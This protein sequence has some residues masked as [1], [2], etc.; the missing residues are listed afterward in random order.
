MRLPACWLACA[1]LVAAQTDTKLLVDKV[2]LYDRTHVALTIELK[3]DPPKASLLQ[4]TITVS[5][6]DGPHGSVAFQQEAD[7]LWIQVPG[8]NPALPKDSACEAKVQVAPWAAGVTEAQL[9]GTGKFSTTPLMEI[10]KKTLK[11]K[12]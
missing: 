10:E 2:V 8:L 3:P 7:Q 5:C 4:G 11:G 6:A 1:G 9:T 12:F